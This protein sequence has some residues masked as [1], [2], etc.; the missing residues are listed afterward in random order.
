M[1]VMP[2]DQMSHSSLY[3]PFRATAATS[4]A[5]LGVETLREPGVT[6]EGGG[7]TPWCGQLGEEE[8]ESGTQREPDAERII[9]MKRKMGI[10]MRYRD[11]W[12]KRET[13]SERHR[14]KETKE[15]ILRQGKEKL[16]DRGKQIRIK[17]NTN[18]G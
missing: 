13:E 8:S 7:E 2:R 5:I 15:A 3:P 9:K 4:G 10:K 18:T 1:A 14:N 11:R 6:H 12:E 16:T 17:I